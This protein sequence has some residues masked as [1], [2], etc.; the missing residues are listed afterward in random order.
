[1]IQIVVLFGSKTLFTTSMATPLL[2]LLG[3]KQL[4]QAIDLFGE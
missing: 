4:A 1:M 2:A 3:F